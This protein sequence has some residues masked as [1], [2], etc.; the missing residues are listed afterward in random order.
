MVLRTE[1][2]SST[3]TASALNHRSISTDLYVN[4]KTVLNGAENLV[5]NKNEVFINK[6]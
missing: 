3:R 6:F 5:K 2:G 1:L 4:F